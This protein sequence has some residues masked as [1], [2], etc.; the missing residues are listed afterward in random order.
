MVRVPAVL[1]G[2]IVAYGL[3]AVSFVIAGMLQDSRVLVVALP[4][5]AWA[6]GF[7]AGRFAQRPAPVPGM[8]I[9]LMVLAL[10]A[11]I[12][13]GGF[14]DIL[15]L[16]NPAVALLELIA[17]ITGGLMGTMLM[18][19]TNRVPVHEPEYRAM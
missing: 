9:G 15:L 5:I 11:G 4:L 18:R 16:I 17:A 14:N 10:R 1:I 6:G 13:L 12:G 8:A 2:L 19:R 7:V 3:G